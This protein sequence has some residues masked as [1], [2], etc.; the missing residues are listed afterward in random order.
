MLSVVAICYLGVIVCGN[1]VKG[2][3]QLFTEP[4]PPELL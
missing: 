3:A 2:R 4:A 1:T